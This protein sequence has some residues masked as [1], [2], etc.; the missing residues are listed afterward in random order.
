MKKIN[1]YLLSIVKD[2]HVVLICSPFL[3]TSSLFFD[4]DLMILA[5]PLNTDSEASTTSSLDPRSFPLACS[6]IFL[7]ASSITVATFFWFKEK[8]TTSF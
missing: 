7:L 5:P 6:K 8:T 4:A 1:T 2:F 3:L